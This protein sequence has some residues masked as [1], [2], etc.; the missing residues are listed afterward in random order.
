MSL[1]E[2]RRQVE[3]AIALPAAG[4]KLYMS[5]VDGKVVCLGGGREATV[6]AIQ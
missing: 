6:A 5:T 1:G 3:S 4:G 2:T